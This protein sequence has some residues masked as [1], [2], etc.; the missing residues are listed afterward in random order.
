MEED[1]IRPPLSS[2]PGFGQVDAE[3]VIKVRDDG[4]FMSID[5][6]KIRAKVGKVALET[7][8]E[9]GVLNGMSQSNQLS[10]FG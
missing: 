7:L 3:N 5:D 8:K 6:L 9:A 4:K 2:I 1:G 10:L